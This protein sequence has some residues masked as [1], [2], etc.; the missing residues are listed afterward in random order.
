MSLHY[1]WLHMGTQNSIHF[2]SSM[3]RPSDEFQGSLQF[4]GHGPWPYCE[5]AL[6][7]ILKKIQHTSPKV[8][9]CH[10][11]RCFIKIFI[12]ITRHDVP[13]FES[14]P[15]LIPGAHKCDTINWCHYSLLHELPIN[16]ETF[17]PFAQNNVLCFV[18]LW[19]NCSLTSNS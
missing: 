15:H 1:S 12:I 14:I 17:K 8:Y 5:V 7:V 18:P 13:L 9:L 16:L 3:V 2:N 19:N 10:I 6:N 4:H 11:T